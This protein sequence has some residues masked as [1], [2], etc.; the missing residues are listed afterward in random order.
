[1]VRP[2]NHRD[3]NNRTVLIISHILKR[4]ARIGDIP[5]LMENTLTDPVPESFVNWICRFMEFASAIWSC[6]SQKQSFPAISW[7][8]LRELKFSFHN[9]NFGFKMFTV[10]ARPG[11]FGITI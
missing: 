8:H 5:V 11:T 6:S 1:M 4:W 2:N 9:G 10:T 7:V 3:K